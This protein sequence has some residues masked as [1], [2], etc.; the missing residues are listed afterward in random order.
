[1]P[2]ALL[3]RL[4]LGARKRSELSEATFEAL[5]TLI[6][7]KTG[8]HFPDNKRYLLES[9]VGR[10]LSALQMHTYEDYYRFLQN[11]G[12]RQEMPEFINSITINETFFFRQP[13][14]M[15]MLKNDLVPA[16][17]AR[18]ASRVRIWS[19]ACSTGDEPYTIA[20]VIK[21][22][23]QPKYP[24]VR[25]E[26]VGTDIN[27]EVLNTARSGLYSRYA[28][29]NIPEPIFKRYF[30]EAGD[31]F[32]LSEDV[33]RMVAYKQVNLMDRAAMAGLFQFDI[34]FCAN[35]LIYFDGRAKQQVVQALYNSLNQGGFLLLSF[36]ETLYGVSQSF[37]PVRFGKN[38]AYQ[39]GN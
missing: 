8:I 22:Q 20:L 10:R 7:D 18:G 36:S 9:R 34:V 35:V 27:S 25:F 5:R 24:N 28:V 15:E 39:K 16:A 23:L 17:V 14:Q 38:I 3:E 30:K 29:R 13:E 19:A 6:Y 4:D 12:F 2:S 31:Q 33:R 26:V 21:E 11:G 37:R 32:Q 1:M